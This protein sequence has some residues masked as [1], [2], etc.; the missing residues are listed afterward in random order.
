MDLI[1]KQLRRF[2]PRLGVVLVLLS[3]G[4]MTGFSPVLHAHELDL[5]HVHDNCAPCHWS[6]SNLSVDTDCQVFSAAS[7]FQFY[8]YTPEQF[9][10]QQSRNRVLNRGP[11]LLS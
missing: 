8:F 11:P 4:I 2:L 5:T 10:D 6:Q 1:S 7:Q 3:F 9:V